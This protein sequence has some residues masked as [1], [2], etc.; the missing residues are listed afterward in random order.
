[1]FP[2]EIEKNCIGPSREILD[3]LSNICAI[4]KRKH[5]DFGPTIFQVSLEIEIIWFCFGLDTELG[6]ELGNKACDHV[7]FACHMLDKE[8]NIDF[9]HLPYQY[10]LRNPG[11]VLFWFDA[12]GASSPTERSSRDVSLKLPFAPLA[13]VAAFR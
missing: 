2:S 8:K 7:E 11:G 1:L 5:Y 4:E 6:F 12:D 10:W 9:A 3:C 13:L